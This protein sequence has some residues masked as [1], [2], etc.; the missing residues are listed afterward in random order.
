MTELV[1]HDPADRTGVSPFDRIIR[2][3]TEDMEVL[4]ACPYVSSD[5]FQDI[6]EKTDEW[7]LLTDVREWLS[8]HRQTNREAIQEFLIEHRDYVRHVSDLH[9]KV[10][11]G[12]DRAL[13]GSAN[14]TRKDS[15]DERRCPYSS[16]NR[17]LSM[18]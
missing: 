16:M 13:I 9:A 17:M 15:P 6:T 1:Y 8:I 7:F 2:E 12:G 18:N 11:V 4:I 10:V 5:Y 14:F 3:I